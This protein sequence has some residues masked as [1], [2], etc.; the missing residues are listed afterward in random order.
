METNTFTRRPFDVE[1]VQVT[2]ENM[3]AV[4]DWCGGKIYH[5]K[6]K[7]TDAIV[8]YIKVDTHRPLNDKQKMAF[9][10]DWVLKAATGFK[11]YTDTAMQNSFEA[12]QA[13][14]N[15]FEDNRD[16]THEAVEE[17]LE[18]SPEQLI[19]EI[20]EPSGPESGHVFTKFLEEN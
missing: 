9:V 7:G 18:E 15:V 20:T 1:A 6:Q 4:A 5:A 14:R 17:I 8:P 3:Q 2:D 11:I 19:A 12:R 10:G 16:E 13:S